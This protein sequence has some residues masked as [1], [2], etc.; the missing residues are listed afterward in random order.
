MTAVPLLSG[1]T[2]SESAD[3]NLSYPINL[4][5]VP[6]HS[7][8]S[9][10]YLRSTAGAHLFGAGPGVDRG[11]I[12][13]NGILYRVMGTKLVS[14]SSAG[15][16]TVL[17]DVGGY[18]PVALDYGFDRLAINSG[19]SLF[20]WNNVA[21]TQV[22][23]PD[24]GQVFDMLWFTGYYVTTDGTSIVVT[25][26]SDPT[27]VDPLKYGSAE[28]DPDMVEALFKLRGEL[29]ALGRYTIQVFANTGGSGFP[30]TANTSATVPVGIVGPR[31]KCEF[32][33]TLA[34][35]GS[36]RGEA[37]A[38]YILD[39]GNAAKIS[40]RAIDDELAKVA[41]QSSITMES[42]MSRD[43]RRLLIHL[44]D[45]T[46]VYMANAT[47]IAGV[48]VWYV[49]TSGLG[50][51]QQYRLQN[52]VLC[53]N[54]WIC[55]DTASSKLGVLDETIATQFGDG[56]GWQFDTQLLYNQSKGAIVHSLELTGLPGRG[57]TGDPTAFMSYT[58]DGETWSMER[59]SRMGKKGNRTK[60]IVWNNHKR[61]RNYMGLR[62]RGG[63][64]AL[65]GFSGLNAE[66]EALNA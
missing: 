51:D 14:V 47:R 59:A 13:W 16:V 58:L 30:F 46:L 3:F 43:E 26:L 55:G 25:Q 29:Y 54:K 60:R 2:S 11:G 48:P 57:T 18:G 44:P 31:A 27:S 50:M 21:L 32:Y 36:G 52:A 53:Y 38:V 7:G 15:V 28:E 22:T 66:L 40:T 49:A 65:A 9:E 63:S 56:A 19:T 8:L 10:G 35:T 6:L 42:R 23:D 20:Y 17:G 61:F 37:T 4:E 64:S 41:D 12:N 39:G 45:K 24:L 62:F 33:Q 5:P 34:F 1:C